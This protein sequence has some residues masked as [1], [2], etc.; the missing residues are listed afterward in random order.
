MRTRAIRLGW[1][2]LWNEFPKRFRRLLQQLQLFCWWRPSWYIDT[3]WQLLDLIGIPFIYE[4]TAQL[5]KWR[6]RPLAASE[7]RVLLPIFGPDF[8][9]DRVLIDERARVGPPQLQICYVSFFTINSYGPMRLETLV[10]EM[11]HVWQYWRVGAVYIP[12]ALRAQRSIQAY[13]YG[14][15]GAL[16]RA[17]ALDLGLGAFN[18]EQQAD[19]IADSY[20]VQR[21]GPT[22]W[23]RPGE[24]PDRALFRYFEAAL[25]QP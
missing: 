1:W 16:Q 19:I 17:K 21:G 9:Y 13:D 5:V 14:G 3:Y 10:H 18:Y 7:R 4:T 8:P 23:L 22:R 12:R 6:T 2:A 15:L 11:V 24:Q 20:Q 25:R